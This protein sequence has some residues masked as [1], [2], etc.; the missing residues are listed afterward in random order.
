EL[1]AAVQDRDALRREL[2]D[3]A[4]KLA[5]MTGLSR[6]L[7]AQLDE[8]TRQVAAGQKK[9]QAAEDLGRAAAAQLDKTQGERDTARSQLADLTKPRLARESRKKEV[10]DRL[11]HKGEEYAELDR[12]LSA[13]VQRILTLESQVREKDSLADANARRA[14]G[15]ATK[16][17]DTDS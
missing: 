1:A 11:S 9:L 8:T 3:A 4:G 7:Q 10:E 13:A 17:A 5:D 14:E 2:D 15:L 12:K 6:S 16:L